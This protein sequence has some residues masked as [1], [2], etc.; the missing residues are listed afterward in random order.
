[1]MKRLPKKLSI[2]SITILCSLAAF[3][4]VTP[5]RVQQYLSAL[6]PSGNK[7]GNLSGV[8]EFYKATNYQTAWIRKE[9]QPELAIFLYDRYMYT[10]PGLSTKDYAFN[11]P[12]TFLNSLNAKETTEDS[13]NTEIRITDAAIQFYHDLAYGNIRP[14][15]G[16]NGLKQPGN[17]PALLAAS[18]SRKTLGNLRASL[19]FE[20]PEIISIENKI[21]RYTKIISDTAFREITISS[22]AVNKTNKPLVL[23]LYQL[24]IM[25][26]RNAEQP[27]SLLKQAVKEAQR[28]FD[29]PADGLLKSKTLS[30]LNTP[31]SV[32]LEQLQLS[33]NYYRWLTGIIQNRS[34]IVVNIPAAYLKVYRKN[35]IILGMRM[36]VGKRATPTPTLS[37][38]VQNVILYPYWHV[39]ASIA[40]KELLP[41]IKRDPGYINRGNYQVLNNAGRIVDPYSVNWHALSRSYFPYTLRQSTGC[42]NALGLLKLDFDSPFGVYLHD[43]PGKSLFMLNKRFFSHGCMRMEKPIDMGHL[44][45]KNN[46]IAID[47]LEQKGCLRNQSPITVPADEQM[48]VIVW[49]NP[50]GTDSTGRVVFYEDVYGKFNWKKKKG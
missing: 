35:E 8:K 1:M 20:L 42:D 14:V 28:T 6:R 50:T 44:V 2:L 38:F 33:V 39:P 40:T 4:Q 17:I 43:T 7:I 25:D 27:D 37:S 41:A 26:F 30:E 15:L 22:K 46:P 5:Q 19:S 3:S 12:E 32:R 45:L 10:A 34:V 16:Y 13:L 31:L 24:G 9:N 49:Y 47:T 29:L 18:V 11:N 48:P 36:I 21:N 23:K